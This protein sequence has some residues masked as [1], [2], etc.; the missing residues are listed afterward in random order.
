MT[1]KRTHRNRNQLDRPAFV[2]GGTADIRWYRPGYDH[3]LVRGR[4]W[5]GARQVV[6]LAPT[7]AARKR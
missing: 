7:L 4:D 6:V 1:A 5:R 2:T 3:W